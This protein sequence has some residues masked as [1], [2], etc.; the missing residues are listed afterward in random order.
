MTDAS[1]IVA[2]ALA[3]AVAA[4]IAGAI[5]MR[6]R[7]AQGHARAITAWTLATSVACA[8]AAS[9]AWATCDACSPGWAWTFGPGTPGN[10]LVRFDALTAVLLPYALVLALATALAV[11]QRD[12]G[13]GSAGGMLSG[14]AST[15]ALLSTAQP[16]ALAVLWA[17]TAFTTWRM[18]GSEPGG[19]P[20]ARAYAA[21]MVPA[22]VLMAAGAWLLASTP[23][24]STAHAAGAWLL[25]GAVMVRK[26]IVPFHSWYPA[27]FSG[28]PVATALNATMPQVAAYTAVR[29][30]VSHGTE[31]QPQLGVLAAASL[32]T[33]VYGAALAVAQRDVRGLVGAL[34]VSQSA[35]V[36]AGLA[37]GTQ[38]ELSGAIAVWVASGIVL[39]G[40]ALVA[41]SLEAR[42]GTLAITAPQGRFADAPGL[43]ACFLLFGL[44]GAGLPGTFSFI[45][46][47]LIVS[48]SLDHRPG[49]GLMVIASTVLAAIALMRGWFRVFGGRPTHGPRHPVLR[50]EAVAFA[51]LLAATFTLGLFPAPFVRAAE[52]VAASVVPAPNEPAN[53]DPTRSSPP[54]RSH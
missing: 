4:P 54:P 46:D 9:W 52:R 11:P 44:A 6:A 3:A 25:T 42:A 19:R 36:L 24:G 10:E 47:D 34:A 30:L 20:A 49:A 41:R 32:V 5:A 33:C 16:A 28:A 8:T 21:Y 13:S 18:A 48:G 29:L 7:S 17:A 37:D 23:A 15:A 39:T 50:R 1:N 26:G 22:V 40:V 35:L 38:A 2:C 43:A 31:V 27:L 14:A 51:V 53:V 12:L 45:A